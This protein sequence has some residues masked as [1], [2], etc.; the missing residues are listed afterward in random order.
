MM[1]REDLPD[2]DDLKLWQGKAVALVIQTL[3]TSYEANGFDAVAELDVA[4]LQKGLPDL[5][6]DAAFPAWRELDPDKQYDDGDYAD[7]LYE[8]ERDRRAGL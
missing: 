6:S 5:L 7:W 4:E 3:K 1:Q 8:R 2:R